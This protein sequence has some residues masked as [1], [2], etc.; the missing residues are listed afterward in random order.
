[1]TYVFKGNNPTQLYLDALVSLLKEGDGVSPRGKIVKEIRP[2]IFEFTDPTRKVTF[3]KGRTIN[4]FFQVAE[5][6]W[7]MKGRSDV[8]WLTQYNMN[9]ASFSDDGINFNAPYGER[10]RHWN[11]SNANEFVLNPMDQLLDVLKKIEKDEFT[12]QAVAVI[13]NPIF[14][15]ANKETLDRPCLTGDTIISS[16]EGDIRMDALVELYQ[17]GNKYPVYS[18]NEDSEKVEIKQVT[19]AWLSKENAK[20]YRITLKDGTVLKATDNHKFYVRKYRMDPRTSENG[21]NFAV[22]MLDGLEQVEVKNL[23]IGDSLNK[24]NKHTDKK[25][26]TMVSTSSLTSKMDGV[27]PEH[28]MYMEWKSGKPLE[29]EV[30]HHIDNDK[31]NNKFYNLEILSESEHDQIGMLGNSRQKGHS[32]KREPEEHLTRDYLFNQAC[33]VFME[34]GNITLPL[35]LEKFKYAGPQSRVKKH[36]GTFTKMKEK[37]YEKYGE[38][39][40]NHRG[41]KSSTNRNGTQIVAIEEC[42]YEDV[43]DIEVEDNHNF[44]ANGILTHN[45]N[46]ILTFKL[47]NEKLDLTVFNRSNDLHWGVFGANLC[48]FSTILDA[49]ASWL[50]VEV[51]TYRQITDS[52][53]IYLDD[54]GAKETEKVLNAYGLTIEDVLREDFVTPDVTEIEHPE[55]VQ[56]V[57]TYEE[58]E[59]NL[60]TFFT[61]IDPLISDPRTYE[62]SSLMLYN[63]L[64]DEIEK[65]DDE[66]MRLSAYMMTAYQAHKSRN[67][68]IVSL[69]MSQIP[70][71]EWKIAGLRFLSKRHG[72]NDLFRLTYKHLD[73]PLRDY[74]DRKEG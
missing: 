21:H 68:K 71:C 43:Y 70:D 22:K 9:M 64:E 73:K 19:D 72:D 15:H 35:F 18:Y 17:K 30:V 63:R 36:F 44:F 2:A 34:H 3:L 10:L 46:L 65:I 13:Y 26:Y 58:Y 69:A 62:T 57:G 50:N 28:R 32:K 12:R 60:E 42:G 66:Y 16:P 4:P 47:R 1:M 24:L 11:K 67:T 49:V 53:H 25:G 52:L 29:N 51:G 20:V 61:V 74:I 27:V 38:E 48:Q 5:A 23:Q 33:E 54:F 8:E 37:V 14:D 39:V 31:S 6:M 40:P 59:E 41:G 45:C 55:L 56:F 7:I